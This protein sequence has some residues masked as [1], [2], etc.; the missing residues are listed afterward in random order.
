MIAMLQRNIIYS[1]DKSMSSSDYRVAT[2]EKGGKRPRNVSFNLAVVIQEVLHINNY[3]DEE[4]E[5]AWYT[6]GDYIVMKRQCRVTMDLVERGLI[7]GDC[8]DHC[9]AGL[10]RTIQSR[11]SSSLQTKS[12][13]ALGIEAVMEEQAEQQ[14]SGIADVE[15]ISAAYVDAISMEVAAP[16]TKRDLELPSNVVRKQRRITKPLSRMIR[17]RMRRRKDN[18]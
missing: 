17:N 7:A 15:A 16:E 11:G 8:D 9:T 10:E 18:Q 5:S 6:R 1:E 12:R 14:F 2:M 4:W 3:T 13:M